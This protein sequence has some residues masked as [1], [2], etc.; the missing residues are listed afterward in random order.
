M[1]N[2]FVEFVNIACLCFTVVGSVLVNRKGNDIR[3]WVIYVIA[4]SL[5]IMYFILTT[6]VYQLCIWVFFLVNDLDAIRTRIK[7]RKLKGGVEH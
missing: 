2:W 1:V 7:K 3:S 4:A 6:N 5:G